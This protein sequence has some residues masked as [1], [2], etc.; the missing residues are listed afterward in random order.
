MLL[1]SEEREPVEKVKVSFFSGKVNDSKVIQQPSIQRN[2]KRVSGQSNNSS[3]AQETSAGN[4]KRNMTDKTKKTTRAVDTRSLAV[5]NVKPTTSSTKRGEQIPD[6]SSILDQSSDN[7]KKALTNSIGG[8]AKIIE[9][10]LSHTEHEVRQHAG[11]N[12][13]KRNQTEVK[14][15]SDQI[16]NFNVS[17]SVTQLQSG[18]THV[19]E[20]TNKQI[21]VEHVKQSEE[22]FI[23]N[24]KISRTN[25][26]SRNNE[27][28]STLVNNGTRK[29]VSKRPNVAGNKTGKTRVLETLKISFLGKNRTWHW[30][31][32]NTHNSV[33]NA[34]ET[35]R[36]VKLDN[37]TNS[38]ADSRKVVASPKSRPAGESDK[39]RASVLNKEN[40]NF[41]KPDVVTNGANSHQTTKGDREISN[42]K[43]TDNDTSA[44]VQT[45]T[46]TKAE[47]IIVNLSGKEQKSQQNKPSIATTSEN[48]KEVDKDTQQE[49]LNGK[50]LNNTFPENTKMAKTDLYASSTPRKIESSVIH[51]KE[52]KMNTSS[53]N[54]IHKRAGRTTSSL[55]ATNVQE[56]RKHLKPLQNGPGETSKNVA[57]NSSKVNKTIPKENI[58]VT[59]KDII[60][61]AIDSESS[62]NNKAGIESD[63][64]SQI[65][66][67]R[68]RNALNEIS[69]QPVNKMMDKANANETYR[70][71]AN[72]RKSVGVSNHLP[73]K[74]RIENTN[75]STT[76]TL[77]RSNNSQEA[78]GDGKGLKKVQEDVEFPNL[79]KH[80]V[81]GHDDLKKGTSASYWYRLLA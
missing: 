42:T 47:K 29:M 66:S 56:D 32:N 35:Q 55:T 69:K 37:E 30:N 27:S 28:S 52:Q 34:L 16:G 67:E 51:N 11:E 18:V 26:E 58:Q 10:N 61:S 17:D 76:N 4:K 49:N 64:R 40:L 41:H 45:T 73:K 63:E 78:T 39:K 20:E 21:P 23:E 46:S 22:L 31:Q 70:V 75:I 15:N 59:K 25:T 68:T 71:S 12:N 54:I 36:N 50:I 60:P 57:L 33:E 79:Q 13:S 65:E 7:K 24:D 80:Q 77:E 19:Q 14:T 38:K 48:H 1:F 8:L 5:S 9:T 2:L 62:Q 72:S 6:T 3:L 74:K 81:S 53:S 43:G 44:K